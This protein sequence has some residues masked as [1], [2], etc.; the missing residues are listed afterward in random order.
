MSNTTKILLFLAS[1]FFISFEIWNINN[2]HTSFI[3]ITNLVIWSVNLILI[4]F[5]STPSP[6]Q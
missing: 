3:V 1:I 5:L 4:L 6:V 2:G